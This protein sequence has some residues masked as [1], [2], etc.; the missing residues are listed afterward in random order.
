MSYDPTSP[1][2]RKILA[3]AVE[4]LMARS[5][6]QAIERPGTLEK[7]FAREVPDTNGKV[8]VLVYSSIENGAMRECGAD[9]IRVC[10]VYTARDG[11]ERGIASAEKRVHR[12]GEI[13]AVTDRLIERMR[14]VWRATKTAEKCPQCSAPMFKA[15]SSGKLCCADLCWKGATATTNHT[16]NHRYSRFRFSQGY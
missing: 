3:D 16:G 4:A 13:S 12:V 11:Q 5:L 6:F 10:A 8:R 14:E 1:T 2:D 15:K 7:V 9:A